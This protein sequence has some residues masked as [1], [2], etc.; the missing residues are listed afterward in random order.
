METTTTTVYDELVAAL[1]KADPNFLTQQAGEATN[2]YYER[3]ILGVSKL[4]DADWGALSGNAQEW[5][6]QA[7]AA[8]NGLQ[9]PPV[10]P[11]YEPATETATAESTEPVPAT[12]AP[13]PTPK[14]GEGS[15]A[16]KRGIMQKAREIALQNP[17]QKVAVLIA[18]LN[19]VGYADVSED[20][21]WICLQ[22]V[23]NVL[24]AAE[25]SGFHLVKFNSAS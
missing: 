24:K 3:I 13:I 21:A 1:Q 15:R 14:T 23:R 22:E 12:S 20:T 19:A 25:A 9:P 7:G 2:T 16:A 17:E 11:G 4:P 18:A 6:N 10:C 8:F 5:F